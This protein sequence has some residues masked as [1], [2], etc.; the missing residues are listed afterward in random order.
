MKNQ[1]R[2]KHEKRLISMSD[3]AYIRLDK[4]LENNPG[5]N[6]SQ[7]LS[8]AVLRLSP[9]INLRIAESK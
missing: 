5:F 9:D 3:E 2:V 7:I 8:Y 4:I 6:M 1:N